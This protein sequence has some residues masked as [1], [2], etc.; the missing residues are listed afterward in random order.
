MWGDVGSRMLAPG[1]EASMNSERSS[2]LMDS[3]GDGGVLMG[4]GIGAVGVGFCLG[5]DCC[6]SNSRILF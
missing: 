5:W 1:G 4:E 6:V 2:I 3:L